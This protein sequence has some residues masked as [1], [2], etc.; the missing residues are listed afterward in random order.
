MS[1]HSPGR[2][3]GRGNRLCDFALEPTQLRLLSWRLPRLEVS[4]VGFWLVLCSHS[5]GS[6]K[7]LELHGEF[8]FVCSVPMLL[9]YR[10]PLYTDAK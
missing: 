8:V 5:P 7:L 10:L 6:A 3:R 9:K 4:G 1:R 2:L